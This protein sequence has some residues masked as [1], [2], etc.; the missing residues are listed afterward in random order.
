VDDFVEKIFKLEND[1]NLQKTFAEN[2]VRD[3]KVWELDY[4]TKVVINLLQD[5]S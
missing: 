1:K 5:A 2:G 3:C 4:Q